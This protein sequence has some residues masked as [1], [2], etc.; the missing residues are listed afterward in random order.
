MKLFVILM[1][2]LFST[3]SFASR[4]LFQTVQATYV[5]GPITQDTVWTLV[6]SPFVVSKG[7]TVCSNATLTIEPEVEVKFGGHFS[8][9][10]EG[11]LVAN[12]TED[13]MITFTSNKY[14]PKAGDWGVIEF[15]GMNSSSLIHC[16]IEYGTNGIT[17]ES[18]TLNIQN[19]LVRLNSEN[20]IM[21]TN[22][23]VEVKNNEIVNNTE[24]GIYIAGGNQVNVQNNN[25]TSN[26]DGIT[27]T[28]NATSEIN[29]RQN[30]ILFNGHSGILLEA[31][32]Y[33]NT[34][35]V[36]NTLS[37]NSY[38]FYVSTNTSTYITHNY[39]S[40]N[41]VGIFYEEGKDHRAYFNDI[42]DNSL[43]MDVYPNM[44]LEEIVSAEY[45]YWGDKSGP[46]H[47]SLNPRGKGNPVRGGGV[48][49]DFIFF[50]TAPIDY[51]NTRPT[52]ILWTDKTLVAPNQTVTFIGTDSYDDGCVDQYFFDFGDGMNSSWTTL[53]LFAHNYSSTGAY[54][55]EL[56][57]M[58]DFGNRSDSSLVAISV[59]NLTPLEASI[60]LSNY[61]VNYN[62]EVLVT[63]YVSDGTSAVENATVTLFS[64]KGGSFTPL[65]GLTDST[66]YFTTM[67]TAPNVTEITNVGIIGRA[68]KT[69]YADGSDYKYLKVLPPLTVQVTAEPATIK[70]EETAT[71]TIHVTA[72]SDQPVADALLILWSDYGNLSALVGVTDVNGS[73]TFLFTAPQTL[74]QI[75]VI[76][77][78]T[79]I[80]FGYAE[81]QGQGTI[82]VEPK[83]LVVEITVDPIIIVSEAAST[84][85]TYVTC[86]STPIS[87]VTVTASSDSGGNFSVVTETTDS[88]GNTEFFFT[89]PKTTTMIS[90]TITV[91]ATKSEYVN[92]EGQIAI[93]I[94]PKVLAV[95]STAEPNATVSEAK[96]N[97]TVHVT[98]DMISVPNA[99]VT[100][101]SENG[102]YFSASEGLTDLY[103]NV[104][105]IFT[106]PQVNEQSNI[107]ITVQASKIGY[108]IGESLLNIT[109]N[110][111][112]LSVEVR[113]DPFTI[114]S[115]ESNVVTVCAK[116][117]ETAVADASVTVL[118]SDGTFSAVIGT[119]D[120]EGCCIL[121]FNA[122]R[123]ATQ[124]SIIV[125]ANVTKN[126]YISGE[127]ETTIIVTPE[128]GGGWPL[129]TILLIVIPIIIVVIIAVLVK[130]KVITLSAEEEP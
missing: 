126:G 3:I 44:N 128:A 47:E 5:E 116:C 66:G 49:L 86:D 58:D 73:A 130:L 15:N 76:V 102:G 87:D 94:V 115:S 23:N 56:T 127:S 34:V 54:N 18:G 100:V 125:V 33:Y 114:M 43:G 104:I 38:G 60:T 105:F 32:A 107:T 46:Y 121:V 35:I 31:D 65:S 27:L 59:Q 67:F 45:N 57:V 21:I 122:P 64:V 111:G 77:T 11:R 36:D 7:I 4:T 40:N 63:I 52:A 106:V 68:S 119:T 81:E 85:I 108:T 13:K 20:G 101:T 24:S 92:G 30:E 124:L 98:Y 25:I 55:A 79:A 96:I 16:I 10:V 61:T 71:V 37:T 62:D 17:M 70:S 84:V 97:V 80:K 42:Y 29:I 120:S 129:T 9:I 109:V 2:V 14:E 82:T 19:S 110:P 78:A 83:T 53:S 41:T 72:G 89:A 113:A 93:T 26:G 50:L 22:G 75:D 95:Q 69:G 51:E 91:T 48:D 112:I 99:S 117:N 39:V 123:T 118:S 12:G 74:S 28:G 90:A 8:L 1:T 88:N 103:G 6:D